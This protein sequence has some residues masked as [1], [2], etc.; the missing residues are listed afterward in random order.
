MP[1]HPYLI[2]NGN[3]RDAALFYADVFGTGEPQFM[4]YGSVHSDEIPSEAANLIM[5]TN[6]DIAGGKLMISD[7]YPVNHLNKGIISPSPT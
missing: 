2:F 6:L 4:T 7:E 1:L 5:H 3:A